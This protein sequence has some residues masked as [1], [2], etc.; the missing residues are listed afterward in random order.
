MLL[1]EHIYLNVIKVQ[2][3]LRFK[4]CKFLTDQTYVLQ[5][6]NCQQRCPNT[7]ETVVGSNPV[8]MTRSYHSVSPRNCKT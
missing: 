6:F 5:F 3:E 4:N 7:L 8:Q 2:Q 1:V